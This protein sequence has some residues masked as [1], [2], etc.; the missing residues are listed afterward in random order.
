MDSGQVPTVLQTVY[1]EVPVWPSDSRGEVNSPTVLQTVYG[2]VSVWPSDSRG[3]VNSSTVLQTVYREVPVWPSDRRREVDSST[4]LQS[5]THRHTGPT[6]YR[7]VQVHEGCTD[8]FNGHT[9]T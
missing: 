4:V 9:R 8:D 3:E 7:C 6:L 1:G 5:R 2:E